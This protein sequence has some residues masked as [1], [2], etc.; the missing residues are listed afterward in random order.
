M[1]PIGVLM[2]VLSVA[3]GGAAGA[4]VKDRLDSSFKE[5]LNL[6]FGICSMSIGIHSIFLMDNMPAVMFSVILGSAIGLALHLGRHISNAAAG[7]QRGITR[8]LPRGTGI[9]EDNALLVTAT[10]LF[11]ASGTGT[12]GA[13][14]SGMTGDHSILIAKAILD[15]FTALIFACSLGAAVSVIA[16]PQLGILL[17]L[18]FC[19]RLIY[20]LTT[21][22]MINDFRACG[23]MIMLTTG[24][25]IAK[26]K[27]FPIADMLPAM[28]LVMP[29][30]HFWTSVLV[31]IIG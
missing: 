5:Q 13:I 25:R 19:A 10:V 21:P 20:P 8:L 18:Y 4:L 16:L 7:M 27:D 15:L 17:L 24:F 11:C 1:M 12:Y 26:I 22:S 6:V 14:I 3:V 28:V 29:F 9:A 2:E 31:P 30:S 23:G